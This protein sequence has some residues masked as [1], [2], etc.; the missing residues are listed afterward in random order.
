MIHWIEWFQASLEGYPQW[1]RIGLIVICA[2][3]FL[4]GVTFAVFRSIGI[5]MD[6]AHG[7]PYD[8]AKKKYHSWYSCLRWYLN[9]RKNKKTE[10]PEAAVVD[11][12]PDVSH[13]SSASVKSDQELLAF[14]RGEK[15]DVH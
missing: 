6:L 4:S 1:M 2:G 13:V 9:E 5:E 7:M 10:A 8:Q 3:V 15:T 11:I 14:C 12:T